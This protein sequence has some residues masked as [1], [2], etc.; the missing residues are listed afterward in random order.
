MK[1]SIK[2]GL[3]VGAT[4]LI[5]AGACVFGYFEA[6]KRAWIR[7][8]E[9]DT[10]A[11]GILQVGDAAPDLTLRRVNEEGT[12]RLSELYSRRPLALVFGSYT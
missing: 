4:L 1:R 6:M 9:Y 10:R 3:W 8:N 2:R 11:E 12:V 7:V 5:L